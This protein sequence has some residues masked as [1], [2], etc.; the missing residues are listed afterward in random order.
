MKA[1]PQSDVFFRTALQRV[2]IPG[3]CEEYGGD[4]TSFATP[5]VDTLRVLSQAQTDFSLADMERFMRLYRGP[6]LGVEFLLLQNTN[7]AGTLDQDDKTKSA[8]AFVTAVSLF[9]NGFTQWESVIRKLIREGVNIH[10]QIRGSWSKPWYAD[11]SKSVLG[12]PLDELFVY[13]NTPFEAQIVGKSWLHT[14]SSEGYD[15]LAYLNEEIALHTPQ[16]LLTW[17][18]YYYSRKLVFQ[19]G[20]N[21]SV[22]WDWQLDPDS[23]AII[24]REVYKSLNSTNTF[25]CQWVMDTPKPDTWPWGYPDWDWWPLYRGDTMLESRRKDLVLRLRRQEN[26]ADVRAARRMARKASKVRR[27]L[28]IKN[29]SQMPGAWPT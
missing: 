12:T 11:D 24:V 29:A 27:S 1:R 10:G 20:D 16:Y 4:L 26:L 14:L 7:L 17:P 2:A 19:L 22:W 25:D 5:I 13:T 3:V 28:G 15:I 9:G 18:T 6:P 8:L 23:G 21:P